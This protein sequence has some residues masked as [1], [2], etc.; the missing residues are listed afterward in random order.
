M[1][2][3]KSDQE[4]RGA[5]LYIGPATVARI[6]DWLSAAGHRDG[7]MF[8]SVRRGRARP[9]ASA[10]AP[11]PFG[12]SSP[13]G[14]ADAGVTGRVSGHSLRVGSA[15]SLAAA[16]ASVVDMQTAGRWKDSTMPA[17]YARGRP[18]RPAVPSH[19]FGTARAR[20][21]HHHG[22]GATT[23]R[24]GRLSRCTLDHSPA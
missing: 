16:G 20:N 11:A 9:R 22:T 15:Q 18:C 3:S 21:P 24:S 23:A 5:V 13:R 17:H 12:P 4:A 19:G 8:R 14:P 1:R 7:A 2:R 10:S 6:E